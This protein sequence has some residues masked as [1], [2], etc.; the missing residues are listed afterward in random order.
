[1]VKNPGMHEDSGLIPGLKIWRCGELRGRS[2]MQLK[3]GVA[4]AVV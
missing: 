1:M 4:V 3:S 2:Q